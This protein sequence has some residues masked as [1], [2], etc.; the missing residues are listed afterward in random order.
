MPDL[1]PLCGKDLTLVGRAHNCKPLSSGQHWPEGISDQDGPLPPSPGYNES[2]LAGD[3]ADRWE[4]V[5]EVNTPQDAELTKPIPRRRGEYPNTD[6]RREYMR[7][8]M[9]KKRRGKL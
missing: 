3:R 9:M 7:E 2:E 4:D 5:N 8:Y 1:C 6:R